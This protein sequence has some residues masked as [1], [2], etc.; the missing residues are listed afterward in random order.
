MSKNKEL[1][2]GHRSRAK[3][4]LIKSKNG[5][6]YDYEI[7]ELLLFHSIPR[8]D[9]K[10]LAKKLIQAFGNLGNVIYASPE[11]LSLIPELGNSTFVLFKLLQETLQRVTKE[12]LSKKTII[13]SWDQLITYARTSI[14]YRSTEN[15]HILFLNSKNIMITDEV[16]EHGSTNSISIYPREIVKSALY[17]DASSIILIHNHPSGITK[18][19][20]A[21]I[22]I[23]TEI[24]QALISIN[25]SVIDHVIISSNSY[26]SFKANGLL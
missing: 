6:L 9:V 14:G 8:K 15:L 2:S 22:S 1:V 7:L 10:P 12:Q 18:P 17:H 13:G 21:D 20:K 11:K 24:Q 4:K 16:H 26:F 25:V 5:S 19:S 23:T 3:E